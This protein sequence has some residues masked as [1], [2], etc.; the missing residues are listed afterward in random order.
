M[1]VKL[2]GQKEHWFRITFLIRMV[3]LRMLFNCFWHAQSSWSL[4]HW[5][6]LNNTTADSIWVNGVGKSDRL[7]NILPFE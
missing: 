6:W 4:Q 7:I 5:F 3:L 1:T 2:F